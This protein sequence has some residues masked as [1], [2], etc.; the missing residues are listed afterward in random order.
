V[1]LGSG[2][3]VTWWLYREIKKRLVMEYYY[4]RPKL[5]SVLPTLY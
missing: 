4:I 2:V 1:L 3:L 5:H